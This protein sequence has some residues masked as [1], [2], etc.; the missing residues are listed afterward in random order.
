MRVCG[1]SVFVC[2]LVRTASWAPLRQQELS[3]IRI[4]ICGGA[5]HKHQDLSFDCPSA[6]VMSVGLVRVM[7]SRMLERWVNT[8]GISAE[9]GTL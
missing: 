7:L 4:M 3:R 2:R 9:R 6:A 5:L 1:S 8:G